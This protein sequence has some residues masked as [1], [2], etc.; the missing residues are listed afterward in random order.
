MK[1]QCHYQG[2]GLEI[3]C[4]IVGVVYEVVENILSKIV[5]FCKIYDDFL[6]NFEV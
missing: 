5:N 2:V 1:L 6:Y 4:V 3:P